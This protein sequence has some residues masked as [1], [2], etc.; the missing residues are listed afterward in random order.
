[1]TK[2]ARTLS[3]FFEAPGWNWLDAVAGPVQGAANGVFHASPMGMKV[4]S[5]LNGTPLRHRVHPALVAVPIGSWTMAVVLDVMENKVL[6]YSIIHKMIVVD[7][8]FLIHNL[9]RCE[10]KMIERMSCHVM[11]GDTMP[12]HVMLLW[13]DVMSCHIMLLLHVS[14]LIIVPKFLLQ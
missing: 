12:C 5:L 7:K 14:V 6:H 11:L 1:M 2:Q 3:S 10:K 4:K 8:N 13:C 9:I